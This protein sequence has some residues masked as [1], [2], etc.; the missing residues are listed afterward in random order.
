MKYSQKVKTSINKQH[1]DRSDPVRGKT[2]RWSFD[3]GPV[4]GKTFEHTFAADGTVR[5]REIGATGGVPT[6]GGEPSVK[7]EA[8]RVDAEVYVVTYLAR[9]GWTLTTVVDEKDRTVVSVASNEKQLVL[10]R[11][12]LA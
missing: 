9:S 3:D 11:G 8:F 4:A 1:A 2:V 12:K 5:W 7:Y 10:Q 6:A